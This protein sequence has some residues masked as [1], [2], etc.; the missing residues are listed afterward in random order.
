MF[1]TGR[2]CTTL[3]TASS[4]ILLLLVRGMSVTCTTF[5]GTWRGVVLA[6]IVLLDPVDERLVEHDAVLQAHEQHHAHVADLAGRPVLADDEALDDLGQ[7]LDL[8]I[9]LRGADA[10][11]ARD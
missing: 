6:R 7:L 9:D 2:P 8:P 3:R 10:H 5:A 1:L 11:A 4:T